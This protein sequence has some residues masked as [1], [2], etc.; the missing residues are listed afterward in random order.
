M[1]L[2]SS[3]NLFRWQ[4]LLLQ[5]V[6]LSIL[7]VVSF[8]SLDLDKG[9]FVKSI[10]FYHVSTHDREGAASKGLQEIVSFSPVSEEGREQ[11]IN[12]ALTHLSLGAGVVSRA[13]FLR[14]QRI[15][16]LIV[17]NR[18]FLFHFRFRCQERSIPFPFLSCLKKTFI[19]PGKSGDISFSARNFIWLSVFVPTLQEIAISCD[20][21]QVDV[22]F[23]NEHKD[24]FKHRSNVKKLGIS[25]KFVA[26]Q[27][28]TRS[29]Q[30]KSNGDSQSCGISGKTQSQCISDLL[31]VTKELE[32]LEI[33]GMDSRNQDGDGKERSLQ[34][35]LSSISSSF[36]SLR[37]FRQLLRPAQSF[38][39]SQLGLFNNLKH[40]STQGDGLGALKDGLGGLKE[41]QVVLP[42]IEQIQLTWYVLHV[43]EQ[44]RYIEDSLLA[45]YI[46]EDR[47][48]KLK[49]V[50]VPKHPIDFSNNI[51][52]SLSG[53]KVWAELRGILRERDFFKSG[54]ITLMEIESGAYGEFFVTSCC[55]IFDV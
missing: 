18:L 22:K 20:F 14:C 42:S 45:T 50:I 44:I 19:C 55:S 17:E 6:S 4:P 21:S 28:G 25:F 1:A 12:L 31:S 37:H 15:E 43:P 33:N 7:N 2:T 48:P 8:M 26:S 23:L 54:K 53:R 46:L 47:F 49:T 10:R 16:E 36:R 32:C 52:T 51:D 35:S 3:R 39:A 30:W 34:I 38:Q 27:S 29:P 24:T 5:S 13:V 41:G 40:W 9:D 11:D